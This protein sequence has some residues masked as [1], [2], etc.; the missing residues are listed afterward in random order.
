M[1]TNL[2]ITHPCY[3]SIIVLQVVLLVKCI[4]IM[5]LLLKQKHIK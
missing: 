2:E 5:I 1:I 4:K 3:N